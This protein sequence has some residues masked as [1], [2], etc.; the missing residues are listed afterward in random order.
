MQKVNNKR[1]KN[2]FLHQTLEIFNKIKDNEV[3]YV[4]SIYSIKMRKTF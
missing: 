4:G 2:A 3:I 1:I